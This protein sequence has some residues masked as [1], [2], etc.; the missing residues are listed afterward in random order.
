MAAFI[1]DTF[2]SRIRLR[3]AGVPI[4]ISCAATRPLPSFVFSS[5][6]EITAFSDS[7][8]IA[9]TMSFSAAGNTSTIRSIVLAADDVCSV[10]NTRWPVSAAVSASRIVSRS[11]SS[12]TRMMSGSSRSALFSALLNDCVCGPTSR[13]LIRQRLDSCTN[14][15]GSSTVRMCP[16]TFSLMWLIIAASVV[17]LPEPVGPVTSTMP[18]GCIAISV[19]DFGEFSC[20]SVRILDGIVRITAP[21]PR[22]CTKAFTRK[23]A[24]PGIEN[25]KSHSSR[26]S[27][28]LRCE[29]FMMS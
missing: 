24:S 25:E 29:S 12:P 15:I 22:S 8:S 14:S 10:P 27:Y 11:R 20:S 28:S 13:W 21:A 17:D 23:R 6:C 16:Y 4:M 19:N 3:I 1:C 18:R 26:S 7:D 5:V 2:A 9:R